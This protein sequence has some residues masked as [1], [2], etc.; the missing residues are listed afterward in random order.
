LVPFCSTTMESTTTRATGARTASSRPLSSLLDEIDD[1]DH[2]PD[3]TATRWFPSTLSLASEVN[4]TPPPSTPPARPR[5]RFHAGTLARWAGPLLLNHARQI[6]IER[7]EQVTYSKG[8]WTIWSIGSSFNPTLHNG[9]PTE[10]VP[11]Y[12]RATHV[13]LWFKRISE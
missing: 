9:D 12:H 7:P 2:A 13:D 6:L 10:A 1:D 11:S 8:Y 4:G 3:S 5:R